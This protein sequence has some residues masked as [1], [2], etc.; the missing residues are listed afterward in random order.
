MQH[1]SIITSH[2]NTVWPAWPK[3]PQ[4]VLAGSRYLT[5]HSLAC[6]PLITFW[7]VGHCF[8]AARLAHQQAMPHYLIICIN[9][10]SCSTTITLSPVSPCFTPMLF[11]W[12]HRLL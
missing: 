8:L 6:P 2:K 1:R 10:S 3:T 11:T 7:L 5:Q 4:R 12:L 9:H